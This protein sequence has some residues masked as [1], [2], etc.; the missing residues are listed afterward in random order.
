VTRQT[1]N[2]RQRRSKAPTQ[3]AL[4]ESVAQT[5]RQIEHIQ[6][7][8]AELEQQANA[9]LAQLAAAEQQM[10]GRI[11]LL[12]E[13]LGEIEPLADAPEQPEPEPEPEPEPDEAP[14]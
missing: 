3:K 14:E 10:I 7:Q 8:R 2:Q 13:Q 1:A 6:R 4:R 9:R 11:R 12:K 5:E